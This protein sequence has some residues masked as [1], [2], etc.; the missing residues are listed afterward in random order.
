MCYGVDE[1]PAHDMCYEVVLKQ[2]IIALCGRTEECD[3]AKPEG[4]F[5]VV[6]LSHGMF[7]C[8]GN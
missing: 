1:E 4:E 2:S 8:N 6:S 3:F 7:A 5:W